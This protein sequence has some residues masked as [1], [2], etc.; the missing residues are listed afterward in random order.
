MN[1][2]ILVVDDEESL[3]LTMKLKLKAAG[4]DVD[5]AED[6]EVA[7]EKL[8]LEK[9]DAVLLDINM[10]R[11]SGIEALGII[12]QQFPQTE[13]IML[14]G[15]ADF[16]TAIECLKNGARDYLVKPI[17]TTELITRL[18]SLLRSKSS[19]QALLEVQRQ[20]MS[21]F[22]NDMMGPLKEIVESLDQALKLKSKSDA[23]E[24]EKL[25]KAAHGRCDTMVKEIQMLLNFSR[26]EIE[27]KSTEGSTINTA[28][29]AERLKKIRE[30]SK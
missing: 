21:I 24:R 3:R 1:D 15:F 25:I 30:S 29:L 22:F 18:K 17:D 23:P 10:P 4:F 5:V 26:D 28:E 8:K 19:E 2:K 14:T 16:S 13:T 9:F 12:R 6:G 27:K 7:I 20:Y 11:M